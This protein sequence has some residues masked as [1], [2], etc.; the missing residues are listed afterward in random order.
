[1]HSHL[2]T[3]AGGWRKENQTSLKGSGVIKFE[4]E[5]WVKELKG[6]NR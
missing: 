3:H 5:L 1:M 2:Y 4:N 6:D